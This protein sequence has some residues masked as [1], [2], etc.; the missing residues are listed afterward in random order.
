MRD[1]LDVH[2]V[3]DCVKFAN[4]ACPAGCGHAL[5]DEP[6]VHVGLNC[7]TWPDKHGV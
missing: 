2:I 5:C 6:C 3:F 7:L 1:E 4:T